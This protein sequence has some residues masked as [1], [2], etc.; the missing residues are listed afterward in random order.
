MHKLT[1]V[2]TLISSLVNCGTVCLRN[3]Q[4]YL[5]PMSFKLFQEGSIRSLRNYNWPIALHLPLFSFSRGSTML[6]AFFII[7]FCPAHASAA[8]TKTVYNLTFLLN[9]V[10]PHVGGIITFVLLTQAPKPVYS[11]LFLHPIW[12]LHLPFKEHSEPL[13]WLIIV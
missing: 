6:Q 9:S 5:P 10:M 4:H 2:F 7:L 1:S 11:I 13:W 3:P 8:G 12:T